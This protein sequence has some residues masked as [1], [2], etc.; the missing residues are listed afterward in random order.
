MPNQRLAVDVGGTFTD[1]VLLD[2]VTGTVSI[3]KEPSQIG[4]ITE[5]LFRATERLGVGLGDLDRILHA[6][7][8]AINTVLQERGATIGVITTQGFRDVLELGRGNRSEV[9]N[10]LYKPPPPLVPR[11]LRQEVAERMSHKGE[12]LVPLDEEAVGHAAQ[13]LAARGVEAIAICFLHAYANP[14]HERRARAVIEQ[15]LPGLPVAIASEITG[16]WREFE[17]TSTVALNAYVMPRMKAYV[18]GLA[19]HLDEAGFGGALNIIQSTGGMLSAEESQRV[20]IRTLESGP[21]GGVIGT[22]ALGRLIGR[23]QLI[24]ADVGGTS[25]DVGLVVDGRPLEASQT[26][27]DRRPVLVP[28]VDIVSVGAGGGS[29]A[30]IDGAGG[31]RVGPQSA[32]ADPGPVCFGR[33]GSE[34]TVTDAHV[35][36]GRINPENFLGQRMSLDVAA[37][38]HAIEAKIAEPL[39]LSIEKAAHGITLLADTNMIHAI[40]RV[41]IER[42]RDPRE[43]SMLAYGGGGGLFAAALARELRIAEA[44]VPVHPAVFSAWGILNADYREDLVR[45][46]VT[47]TGDLD[48]DKLIARFERVTADCLAKLTGAGMD[49]TQAQ[50]LRAAD[51]RYDGQEHTVSVSLPNDA[52]LQQNGLDALVERFEALHERTFGHKTPEH[53]TEIV[54]LRVTASI[55][56]TRPKLSPIATGTGDADRARDG[57]RAVYFEQA[58]GFVDTA[59]Y[60]RSRLGAG[61]RLNGP[62]IVEE[63]NSTTIV[64]PGAQLVVDP[65][66][67]LLITEESGS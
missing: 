11:F 60:A 56:V 45:T 59:T 21:A 58:G 48:A 13:L 32:E 23:S 65:Y 15:R 9:Y 12:V 1:L 20:P 44:I 4:V 47:A 51:M 22:V 17:R 52:R 54:N 64:P 27:V 42:G 55:A 35:V 2:E 43:L 41:T 61:D 33:G 7:T 39:G 19:N 10:L 36:L 49:A 66:G 46:D 57:E 63:W 62:A 38:R 28:T 37:A 50:V 40:R 53:P 6:S 31:F 30:W 67:N 24:A 18:G 25:F 16:E 5:H 8:V 29:I 34:P 26:T 3:E 14:D